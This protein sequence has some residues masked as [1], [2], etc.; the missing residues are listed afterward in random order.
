MSRYLNDDSVS[1]PMKARL[2]RVIESL[3]YKPS[4][5]ARN[6][7]LGLKG[8]IGVVVDSIEDPWFTQL[9]TGMEEELQSRDTSLML[10]S[11]ELR[12]T[13]DPTIA[14]EWI[15]ERR[16]DGLIIA[17]CHRRDKALVKAALDAQL[18]IVA[19]AP[20][21]TL[22]D[23]AVLRA[24]NTAAG[25]TLGAHLAELGHTRVAFAGGPACRSNL[26]IACKGC[27][28]SWPS[29][30]SRCGTRTSAF[31][32]AT[33]PKKAP[34]LRRR[35]WGSRR[36][37]PLLCWAATL[38]QSASFGRR[39]RVASSIPR[40]SVGGGVRRHSGRGAVVAGSDDDGAA[41]A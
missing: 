9:L 10:L 36:V 33:T 40:R 28:R 27:A 2:S 35:S 22:T 1:L 6:L 14:F 31:V 32:P 26:A 16:V 17:K 11:L 13:Y 41:D 15:D 23:V 4:R 12:D 21:Q 30:V 20:D 24:D 19:V 3:G 18:P 8:C 37:Q 29:A 25:R 5:T 38:W 39:S 7:S 34:R